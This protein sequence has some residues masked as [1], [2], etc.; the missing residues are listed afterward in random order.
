MSA[1]ITSRTYTAGRWAFDIDGQKVGFLQSCEGGNATGELVEHKGGAMPYNKKNITTIKYS[2]I[3]FSAGA[4]MGRGFWQWMEAALKLGVLYKNGAITVCDFNYKAQRRMDI[5]NM[6][7][8]KV[9]VP[10]LGGDS[11]E[12]L[13][14]Q[15]E[16]Q[17]ELVRWLKENAQDVKGDMGAKQKAWHC[18]N[19]RFE[20]GGLPTKKLAKLEGISWECKVVPD[21]VGDGREY[22]QIPSTCNVSDFTMHISMRDIDPWAGLADQWFRLGQC[23]EGNEFSAELT[24]LQPDMATSIGTFSFYNVGLREFEAQPKLDAQAD[25][26]ARF[27]VKCYAE[28]V[29]YLPNYVDA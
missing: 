17:S 23:L 9:T 12:N 27:K 11:K 19:F 2:P 1:N 4:G 16:C 20:M 29:E 24:L 3:K 15:F 18:A 7:M 26:L 28:R 21:A 8:S 25:Q 14:Y 10:T 13:Y 22:E 6:L 5:L